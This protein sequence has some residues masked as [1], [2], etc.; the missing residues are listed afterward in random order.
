MIPLYFVL[1][2]GNHIAGRFWKTTYGFG[3]LLQLPMECV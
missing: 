3:K 2:G 1:R